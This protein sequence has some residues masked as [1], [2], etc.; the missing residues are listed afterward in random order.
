MSDQVTVYG[1]PVQID[2][3]P[4]AA[5]LWTWSFVAAGGVIG[6][7]PAGQYQPSEMKAFDAALDAAYEA[8]RAPAGRS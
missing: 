7:C 3:L 6:Q 1:I 8:L 4:A 2:V 5:G